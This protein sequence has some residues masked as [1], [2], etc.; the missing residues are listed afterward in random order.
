MAS[1]VKA[2]LG[3]QLY[4]RPTWREVQP[5][6]GRLERPDY[7]KLVFEL[8]PVTPYRAR[9]DSHSSYFRTSPIGKD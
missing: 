4:V 9:F 5:R 1:G 6:L 3:Q 2:T 7:L 8:A